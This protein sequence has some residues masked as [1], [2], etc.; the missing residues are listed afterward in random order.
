[1]YIKDILFDS[2]FDSLKELKN[3]II[4]LLFSIFIFRIGTY[5]SIPGINIYILNNLLKNNIS[6]NNIFNFFSGGSLY[7]F[8]IFTLGVIPYISSSIIIQ[9]LTIIFPYFKELKKEGINGKYIINKYIKYL[10]FLLSI[11]QSII[12]SITIIKFNN[13]K[14]IFLNDNWY[15]YFISILSLV[16]GTMFLIWLSEQISEYGLGNGISVII[17]IGIISNLPYF[18]YKLL[19]NLSYSKLI[20]FFFLILFII[21]FIIYVESAQRKILVQYAS[22][23][24]IS[25]IYLFPSYS[26]FLPLKINMSGVIPSIF[27]SSIMSIPSFV[28]IFLNNYVESDFLKYISLLFY[29]NHFLYL[30]FYLF[31]IIFFCFFYTLLMY[32]SNDISENLK[33]TGAYIPGIRPGNSTSNYLNKIMLRLT[34]FGSIYI[35]IICLIPNFI[36]NMIGI[37]FNFS[38]TSLLI[39]IIVIMEFI[40]QIKSLIMSNKYFSIFKRYS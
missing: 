8:S 34:L 15:I 1:M 28:L 14:S 35:S 2:I 7:N 36:C 5:I 38:G 22:K 3:R 19:Y 11:I 25:N 17:F 12:I 39:T 30:I 31:F 40:S 33:K 37:D 26:T 16:T 9:L 18:L 21:Y 20:L 6:L 23:R 10:T 32:N 4:F 29:P 24:Y 27:T 13:Y